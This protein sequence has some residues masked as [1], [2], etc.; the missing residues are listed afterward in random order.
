MIFANYENY[1]AG[2]EFKL[3]WVMIFRYFSV[4]AGQEWNGIF[5]SER[6]QH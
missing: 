6:Q 2:K 5:Q 1:P 3:P 4:A